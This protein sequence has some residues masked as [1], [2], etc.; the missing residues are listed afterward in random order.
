MNSALAAL[1]CADIQADP[2]LAAALLDLNNAHASELSW[3]TGEGLADLLGKAWRAWRM[4]SADALL[5]ALD[6]SAAYDNPNH[7]WFRAHYPRFVYVDRIVVAPRG[8]G[9][10]LARQLYGQ[11]IRDAIEAGHE[12]VVC[13]VNIDPPNPQS[14]ALHATLGFAAVG[15]ARLESSAKRVRYL[16]RPLP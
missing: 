15:S 10:G 1:T 9:K 16:M 2:A 11:L 8:R 6:E 7:R 4:G 12:R 3:L 14:D 5:I 13:E